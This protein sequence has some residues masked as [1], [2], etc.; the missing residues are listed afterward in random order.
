LERMRYH[1]PSMLETLLTLS[2]TI[3]DLRYPISCI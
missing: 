3:H 2:S 1:F